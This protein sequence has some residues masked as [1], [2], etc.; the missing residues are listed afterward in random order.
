MVTENEFLIDLSK[1]LKIS[2]ICNLAKTWTSMS[3]SEDA[4]E[5]LAQTDEFSI[6]EKI[7]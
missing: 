5:R 3:K 7:K 6:E 1:R 4:I 2:D